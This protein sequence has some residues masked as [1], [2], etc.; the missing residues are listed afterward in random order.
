VSVLEAPNDLLFEERLRPA[1]RGWL[2]LPPILAIT[3]LAIA[4][5][6]AWFVN[7]ARFWRTTVRV[8]PDHVW[9]G[10]RSAR[11][12]A[13]DLTTLGRAQNTWPWRTFS[14]RWLGA[15]P[16]WTADSV[17]V[18]GFDGGKP[19]WVSVGTN[20]R[21]ALVAV[22]ERAVP[23]ARTRTPAPVGTSGPSLPP[24]GWHPD[25]WD[26]AGGRLRWWDGERWT[27]WTHP[28]PGGPSGVEGSGP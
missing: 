2:W 17:G 22:L 15:N 10:K 1:A 21:E 6:V 12:A 23:D 13:L 27:G 20:H 3:F 28:Q 11:L 24:P 14:P 16:I 4:P 25:P 8:D 26:P 19:L 18:R 9:V 7:I 5:L